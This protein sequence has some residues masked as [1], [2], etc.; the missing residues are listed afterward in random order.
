MNIDQKTRLERV[1]LV[2]LQYLRP[3]ASPGCLRAS[4]FFTTSS[5]FTPKYYPGRLGVA[6]GWVSLLI[7][8]MHKIAIGQRL[9]LVGR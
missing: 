1:L 9:A 6:L 4:E 7:L 2:T 8:G 3:L 5:L